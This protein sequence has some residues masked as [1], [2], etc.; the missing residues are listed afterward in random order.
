MMKLSFIVKF[1][2]CFTLFGAAAVFG[3][4][5]D[6][7]VADSVRIV[8]VSAT[9]P[10][11]DGVQ[12]EFTVDIEYKLES[13]KEAMVAIGFNLDDPGRFRMTGKKKISGGTNT[14]TMKALVSPKDWKERGDF[15]V[16][17]NISPYPVPKHRY[18]PLANADRVVAFD[19]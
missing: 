7:K 2:L 9:A 8:S 14:I 18:T 17:V 12:N 16:Y 11:K 6:E 13:V 15:I 3:Q 5:S 4:T 19:H 10:V 1:A